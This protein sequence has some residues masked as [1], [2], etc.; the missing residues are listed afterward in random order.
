MACSPSMPMKLLVLLGDG[1]ADLPVPELGGRTPLQV[2][3]KPVLDALAR[4]SLCGMVRTVPEGMPTGS[5]TAN[6]SVM[7]YD[8]RRYYSGR[9]PIEAVSMGIPLADDDVAFRCNLVTLGDETGYADRAMVDYSSDEIATEDAAVLIREIDRLLGGN[10]IGFH[11]GK[12]YRHCMVWKGGPLDTLLTP[13]HDILTKVVGPFL[14]SGEGA[15]RIRAIMEASAGILPG[16]PLNL[17]RVAAGH[18]PASSVWIWGQGTRPRMPPL[19]E[20]YPI[21]GSVISAVDLVKGLGI[22]AGL[23]VVDVPGATGTLDTDFDGKAAAAI[24]EFASGQD[25][26]YLHVEAPDECGHRHEV[27]G[28]VRAI[29]RID[30]CI[31]APLLAWLERNRADTGTAYRILVLPDHPTPLTLRTHTGDPVP[32]LLH[33]SDREEKT[34]VA[35]RYDEAACA[36]TGYQVAEGHALFGSFVEGRF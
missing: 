32:F 33:A 23:R 3:W 14:P 30:A 6:M 7:G 25:Y 8:P 19:S 29:E 16:L 10:G 34:R 21:R 35:E 9:S 27:D 2:A 5:D 4:R 1:M 18:R 24:R 28:K 11:P 15:D 13:P 20:R 12:S 31:A 22:C 17:T 36:R 26:V